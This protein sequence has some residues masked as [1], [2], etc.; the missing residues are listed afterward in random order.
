MTDREGRHP[1]K[2]ERIQTMTTIVRSSDTSVRCFDAT[3]DTVAEVIKALPLDEFMDLR[4]TTHILW[5]C[6]RQKMLEY[7]IRNGYELHSLLQRHKAVLP[8]NIKMSRCPGMEIGNVDFE[9][10]VETVAA[11]Y[12]DMNKTE[13]ARVMERE[14]GLYAPTLLSRKWFQAAVDKQRGEPIRNSRW[15]KHT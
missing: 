5:E 11:M 8:A 1:Q 6:S 9:K 14:Y 7:D 13:L 15:H 2:Q 3:D 10:Q 4:V 12:P